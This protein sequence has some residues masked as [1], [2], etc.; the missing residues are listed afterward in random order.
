MHHVTVIPHGGLARLA[1]ADQ[2]VL[3]GA[4]RRC[5]SPPDRAAPPGLHM[6]TDAL[7]LVSAARAAT[8]WRW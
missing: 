5:W 7:D 6:G 4:R 3:V 1:L 8:P 2:I